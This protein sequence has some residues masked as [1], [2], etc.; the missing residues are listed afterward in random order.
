[1][2]VMIFYVDNLSPSQSIAMIVSH[3]G[4]NPGMLRSAYDLKKRNITTVAL[5]NSVEHALENICDHSL[6]LYTSDEHSRIGSLQW[7]ISANYM[8]QIIYMCML[9]HYKKSV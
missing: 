7:M 2:Q 1:M 4:R 9:E 5:T 8:L 3:S 6:H